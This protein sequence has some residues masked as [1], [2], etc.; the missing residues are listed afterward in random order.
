MKKLFIIVTAIAF[1]FSCS[2]DNN[3]ELTQQDEISISAE[4]ILFNSEAVSASNTVKVTSSN[5]WRLTGKKTW[6]IPSLVEGKNGDQVSFTAEENNTGENRSI[7]Y[8]FICGSKIAKLE[9]MQSQNNVIELVTKTIYDVASAG[10]DISV[11]LNTNVNFT[12]EIPDE[13]KEW[14][15]NPNTNTPPQGIEPSWLYFKIAGNNTY[16]A[17]TGKIIIKGQGIADQE[18][19]INQAQNDAI[20]LNEINY[21]VSS[22]GG[23]VTVNLQ[24]NVP[25]TVS[26]PASKQTW[27]GKTSETTAPVTEGL[28]SFQETF[29]VNETTISRV[30][31]ITFAGGA[32]S[33]TAIFVQLSANPVY[34]TIPDINFRNFLKSNDY[35]FVMNDVTGESVATQDGLNAT[36]FAVSSRTIYSLL[37]IEVFTN[38][39]TLNCSSNY[40]TELD[41][42][43]NTAITSL[44]CTTNKLNKL[45]LGDINIT[46]LSFTTNNL[47]NPALEY[48]TEL[49]I[50]SNK[51]RTF[52]CSSTQIITLDMSECP[53]LTSLTCSSATALTTLYLKESQIA[54]LTTFNK[55]AATTVVY[56]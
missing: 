38:L 2:D 21:H 37:G 29:E 14:I 26:I 13:N 11:R 19:T 23:V 20:I 36:S 52:T 32:A 3:E 48:S 1:L 49:T 28:N 4:T 24:S 42:S 15:T 9:V 8:T 56:K 47:R 16:R 43:Y 25:Y 39:R 18:I 46:S 33:S 31:Q 6:C 51:L 35:I 7:T 22:T 10:S 30:A 40:I 12:I 41:L 53:A 54:N 17:R 27:V 45:I 5:D 34:T 55:P 50:V 44:T